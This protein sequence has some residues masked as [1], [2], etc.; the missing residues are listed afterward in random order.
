MKVLQEA[1]QALQKEKLAL[2]AEICMLQRAAKIAVPTAESEVKIKVR[3]G[4][5]GVWVQGR[6]NGSNA[7]VL[8]RGAADCWG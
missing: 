3:M 7:H 5:G 6:Q 2:Q 8:R 4:V 1:Y